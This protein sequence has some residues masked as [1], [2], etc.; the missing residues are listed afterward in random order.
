MGYRTRMTTKSRM[1]I[2]CDGWFDTITIGSIHDDLEESVVVRSDF[3]DKEVTLQR[4]EA[5]VVMLGEEPVTIKFCGIARD[6]GIGSHPVT[7]VFSAG[8]KVKFDEL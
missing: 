8:K 1:R 6:R 2:E 5:M 7:M 3:D 4:G